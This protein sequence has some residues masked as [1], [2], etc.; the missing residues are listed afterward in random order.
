M[1]T[2]D[3]T[4]EGLYTPIPEAP[5]AGKRTTMMKNKQM[6][7]I[8]ARHRFAAAAI[9]LAVCALWAGGGMSAQQSS[10]DNFPITPVRLVAGASGQ[11]PTEAAS[12]RALPVATAAAIRARHQI[13]QNPELGNR[14]FKTAELV[15]AHLRGLGLEVKTGV[16][17]TGVV[18]ILRGARPG[19]T[20]A[21]RADMDALPVFEE[22]PFAFK[23]T[24][25]TTY[26]GQDV[27][28]S[29]ACGHDIHVAVMM[30]V[31]S[32]LAPTRDTLAGNVM[33]I[34]QPAE[35]APP[36]GEEGGSMLMLKEG[37]FKDLRPDV[38][39]GLHSKP[40][41][42]VGTI[43]Y[44]SGPTNATTGGFRALLKGKSSHAASPQLSVDPVVMAAQAVLAFQ[45]IRSRNLPPLE[46]SVITVAQ[47]HGG[48]RDN[49]IPE[50]VRL[51]GTV[52]TFSDEAQNVVERRMREILDGVARG[53]GG[54]YELE[55]RQTTPVNISNPDLVERM[56]PT[57][58]RVLGKEHIV[59]AS[60]VMASDD[61]GRFAKEV[62]GMFLGLGVVKPG[63][64]SGT[65]HTSNFLAD[66]AA[67]PVG[68]Q[69]IAAMVTD[70]LSSER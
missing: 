54:S 28:V 20:V 44:T 3:W 57:L 6:A 14:E 1:M 42:E 12:A 29:H 65:N 4:P 35:E 37:I 70:Y 5:I 21:L 68:M 53:A 16:A 10:S 40:E 56:V 51:E 60:P 17:H 47:I 64:T 49:I 59:K 11:G 39:F 41:W 8:L 38:I 33:F 55:Y 67:I 27:P 24:A 43:A 52:R 63:T 50:D 32:M 9:A 69:A 34:F 30:G 23:S 58:Q 18:G 22:T 15:A 62:P 25:R 31:A 19:K 36:Q 45:T 26:N 61:F 46:P 7:A 2:S 48:I 66:D 13:H